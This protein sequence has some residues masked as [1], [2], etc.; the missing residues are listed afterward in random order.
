M[1]T[2]P[3]HVH[4]PF[5]GSYA[6]DDVTFLLKPLAQVDNLPPLEKERAIQTGKRHYSEMLTPEKLPSADYLQLFTQ[7][8]AANGARMAQ[9]CVVL[10]NTLAASFQQSDYQ[11]SEKQPILISL[12]R[13]G[14]P[15][16]VVLKHLLSSILEKDIAHYSVSIIRDRGI[17][18]NA[19]NFIR[20]QHGGDGSNWVFIDGWTGKGVITQELRKSVAHYNQQQQMR[21]SPHLYVLSDLAGVAWQ[22]ASFDDYLIPSAILN[23]TISGLIS[24]SVLNQQI[25]ADDFHGCLYY[26]EFQSA[27]RS[28]DFVQELL[29]LAKKPEIATLGEG[30]ASGAVAPGLAEKQA[31]QQKMQRF[32]NDICQ[33]F[34]IT[35]WNLIKP[36]LGEATRVLLRR[37]P[38][39]LLLRDIENVNVQHLRVLAEEKGVPVEQRP[40]LLFAA[41]SL[42]RSAK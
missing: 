3:F 33:E 22:A 37:V 41:V 29:Q 31:Q 28:C 25:G 5:H 9:D 26:R 27:D 39:R 38:E 18:A 4:A 12:A 15:V 20:E 10:A 14:T 42:I 2:M 36:G 7:A 23:A 1:N 34:A 13:A 17:D 11:R 32:I 6:A 24:R 40:D 8:L 21:V 19:L 16:G 30:G 35:D